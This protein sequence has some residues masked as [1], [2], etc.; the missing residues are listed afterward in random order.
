MQTEFV[1]LRETDDHEETKLFRG[2]SFNFVPCIFR[3]VEAIG[4]RAVCNEPKRCRSIE[5]R[6]RSNTLIELEGTF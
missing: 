4:G 1:A 5:G 3:E 6:R 2:F